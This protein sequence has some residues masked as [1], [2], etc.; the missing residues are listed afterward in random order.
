MKYLRL[1]ALPGDVVET[2]RRYPVETL[3]C[4]AEYVLLIAFLEKQEL[5]AMQP[6]LF[7]IILI[8]NEL[9]PRRWASVAYW[10]MLVAAP[11]SLLLPW[12]EWLSSISIQETLLIPWI[13]AEATCNQ[14][15]GNN[16]ECTPVGDGNRKI[17]IPRF[18]HRLFV[19]QL[20]KQNIPCGGAN[21][22]KDLIYTVKGLDQLPERVR[23]HW[24]P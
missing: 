5:W 16:F 1:S 24:R 12:K 6:F 11:L 18:P 7:F 4:L 10:A 20:L 9:R 17:Q 15:I 23:Y 2:V 3:F 19:S 21:H 14:R 22:I 8:F 13:L